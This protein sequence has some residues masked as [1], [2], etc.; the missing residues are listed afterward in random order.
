MPDYSAVF[1]KEEQAIVAERKWRDAVE[2]LQDRGL[3]TK[4]RLAMADRYARAYAE[5]ET[6]YPLAVLEGPVKIGPN[7]GDVF[8]FNWSAVE[9]LNERIAKL[10][11]KLRFDVEDSDTGD[12]PP[13]PQ[14]PA[15]DYLD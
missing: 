6:L 10:E 13:S 7:G 11:A 2:A 3:L 5:Y 12:K 9:K 1:D 8:N 14:S 4:A 15:D